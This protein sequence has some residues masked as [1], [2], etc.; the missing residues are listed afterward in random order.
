MSDTKN[1]LESIERVELKLKVAEAVYLHIVLT[2][3]G[4]VN[5]RGNGEAPDGPL[6]MGRPEV[7]IFE[8]WLLSLAEVDP[9]LEH[10]GRYEMPDQAGDPTELIISLSGEN[11]DQGYAFRYGSE[12]MGP[13]EE[14]VA[15]T[16]LALDLT[17][18]WYLDQTQRQ[19]RK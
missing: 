15:L 10:T 3:S 18:E 14:F 8:Q 7:T 12:S 2:R 4:M 11:L 13:P 6:A 19:R 17:E 16:D 5:R 9:H 1:P